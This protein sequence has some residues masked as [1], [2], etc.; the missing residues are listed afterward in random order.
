MWPQGR[1]AGYLQVNEVV[2]SPRESHCATCG[3][4]GSVRVWSLASMELVIQFQV[5][6]QVLRVPGAGG[7]CSLW[8]PACPLKGS[9]S[10]VPAPASVSVLS[11]LGLGPC[12]VPQGSTDVSPLGVPRVASAWLGAP[13]LVHA[14]SSST[15]QQVTVMA[16]CV[17]SVSP[18]LPWSSRCIPTQ[19]H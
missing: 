18:E 17:S 13:L 6:N 7:A 2:F 14:Q 3:D 15:W 1:L 19:P 12:P 8:G 10:C 9:G 5:L 11:A 4:D 16:H